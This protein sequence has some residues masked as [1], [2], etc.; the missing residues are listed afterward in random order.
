LLAVYGNHEAR[1]GPFHPDGLM[2]VGFVLLGFGKRERVTVPARQ[3]IEV[4]F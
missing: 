3:Q 2:A 1:W 4:S